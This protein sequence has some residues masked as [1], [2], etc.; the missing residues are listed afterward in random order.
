MEDAVVSP[1]SCAKFFINTHALGRS[2]VSL[3][4]LRCKEESAV[5]RRDAAWVGKGL[6]D[7]LGIWARS[8]SRVR[9]E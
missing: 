9:C 6:V 2:V 7:Q 8:A 5:L 1:N 3:G 4:L